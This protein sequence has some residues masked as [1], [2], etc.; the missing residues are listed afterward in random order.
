MIKNSGVPPEA[1]PIAEN[2]SSV[3]KRLKSAARAMK[4]MDG[5]PKGPRK[6]LTE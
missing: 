4:R 3:K 5:K 1:L 2:I 6:L